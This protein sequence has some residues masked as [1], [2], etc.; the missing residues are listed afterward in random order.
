MHVMCEVQWDSSKA[1]YLLHCT[2]VQ[3]GVGVADMFFLW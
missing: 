2:Q 3:R 1:A